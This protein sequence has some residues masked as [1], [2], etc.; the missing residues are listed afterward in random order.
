MTGATDRREIP[1]RHDFVDHGIVSVRVRPGK[2]ATIVNVCARGALLETTHRLL[3]GASV[4][5]HLE[6]QHRRATVRGRVL[7]CHVAQLHATSVCY[8]GAILFDCHLPWFADDQRE[9]SVVHG[10]EPRPGRLHG[11]TATQEVV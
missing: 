1:R 9:G 4:E 10:G 3:P 8:R 11:A 2:P 6:T 7:H 5:V